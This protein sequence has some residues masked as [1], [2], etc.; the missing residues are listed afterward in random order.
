MLVIGRRE[1]QA[2]RDFSGFNEAALKMSILKYL[3][4]NGMAGEKCQIFDIKCMGDAIVWNFET[5][6]NSRPSAIH[7][8]FNKTA[9]DTR[10]G[11]GNQSKR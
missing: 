8:V 4:F 10:G 2:K 7:S 1:A 11:W 5:H 3:L 6:P 9:H